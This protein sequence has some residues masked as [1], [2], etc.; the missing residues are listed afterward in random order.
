MNSVPNQMPSAPPRIDQP[1]DKPSAGPTKPIGIVK[2][3]KFPRNHNMAC[4]QVLPCR[5]VS[6]IQSI[7]CTSIWPSS[8][9][10]CSS[11]TVGSRDCVAMAASLVDVTCLTSY[12][13]QVFPDSQPL[14]HK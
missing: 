14:F 4:C 3:W 9:R 6:G 2:Y 12:T 10:S 1:S 5:S 13:L 8:P 11:V 7:E